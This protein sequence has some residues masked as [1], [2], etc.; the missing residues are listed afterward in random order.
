MSAHRLSSAERLRYGYSEPSWAEILERPDGRECD[1][2]TCPSK[3]RR[4]GGRGRDRRARR[5]RRDERKSASRSRCDKRKIKAQTHQVSPT[6]D[7]LRYGY[8]EP[9]WAEILEGPVSRD[10]GESARNLR[11]DLEMSMCS[12]SARKQRTVGKRPAS[13]ELT[14]A[15]ALR[16]DPSSLLPT[17]SVRDSEPQISASVKID[18]AAHR[19]GWRL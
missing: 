11:E 7:D 4:A 18:L 9:S 1:V 14:A 17:G 13:A 15:T 19:R 5:A 6:E 3:T 8:C 2:V 16:E 10:C 12:P